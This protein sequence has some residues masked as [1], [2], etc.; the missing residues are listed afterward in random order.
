MAV[1][2]YWERCAGAR[3]RRT[4]AVKAIGYVDGFLVGGCGGGVGDPGGEGHGGE[5]QGNGCE[6]G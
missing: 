5:G 6:R 1:F 4:A 2:I 3:E